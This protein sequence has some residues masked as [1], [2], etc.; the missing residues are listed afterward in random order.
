MMT[1]GDLRWIENWQ[2]GQHMNK[3]YKKASPETM[4]KNRALYEELYSKEIKWCKE[5]L[6]ELKDNK[7][8]MDMYMILI[9][10][11][12]KMSP[13]MIAAVQKAMK[14]PIYDPVKRIERQE[15]IKPILEKISLLITMIEKL[16]GNKIHTQ[17]SS[18]KFVLSCQKQATENLRLSE[19]QMSALNKTWKKYND[20]LDKKLNKEKKDG[21]NGTS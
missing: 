19:K 20:R 13:K 15:Q 1:E 3:F 4:K 18:Y 9:S 14:N 11:S 16:D 21:N 8:I 7:F 17:W 6:E 10:G 2:Q 5:H 12:R